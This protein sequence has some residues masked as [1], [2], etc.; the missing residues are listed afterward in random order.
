MSVCVCVCVYRGDSPWGL[1]MCIWLCTR[2][3]K[4]GVRA[5]GGAGVAG[6]GGQG[7]GEGVACCRSWLRDGGSPW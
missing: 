7:G 1:Y 2:G 3:C 5:L 4:G 6:A